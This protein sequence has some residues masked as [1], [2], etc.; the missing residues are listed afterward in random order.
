MLSRTPFAVIGVVVGGA[1][2][3]LRRGRAIA[4]GWRLPR[5]L[6]PGAGAQETSNGDFSSTT[7]SV[8]LTLNCGDLTLGLADGSA[9][10]AMTTT[11]GDQHVSLEADSGSLTMRSNN[12]GFPF[13]DDRQDWTVTLGRD[14]EYD[15]SLTLNATD[16]RV[17]LDGGQFSSVRADPNAG[18]WTSTSA[19]PRCRSSTCT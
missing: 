11:E 18:S 2:G 16:S 3:G 19:A 17:S 12:G 8:D 4:A 15:L 1:G 9:W 6:R 14:V 7:A 10:E 5:D 13:R